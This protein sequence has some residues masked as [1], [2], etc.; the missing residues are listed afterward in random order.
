MAKGNILKEA[1]ADAKAV[2]EVAL[3]NAKKA[4]KYVAFSY[5][6]YMYA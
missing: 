3:Q 1:I 5:F 2:R 6:C 4:T